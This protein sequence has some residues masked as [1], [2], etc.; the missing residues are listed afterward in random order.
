MKPQGKGK[1]SKRDGEKLGFPV[2]PLS[3]KESVGYRESGFFPEA[4]LNFLA[5]LGWNPGTEQELFS[6]EAL[7]DAFDLDRVQKS[8]ARFDPEKN[9]W[10]NHQYLQQKP[11]SDLVGLFRPVLSGKNVDESS[12]SDA[13]LSKAI[14]LIRERASF[15]HELW[16]LG[17]YLFLAPESY[18]EKAARKQWKP[19][20]PARM[21]ELATMLGFLEDFGANTTEAAVKDWLTASGLSFGQVMPPLR[22]VLVGMMKGPHLFDIME[23]LGKEET[24]N[25]IDRAIQTLGAQV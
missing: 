22:L 6:K 12:F 15:V 5:L 16:D 4:V 23:L 19:E 18:D 14:S 10:Y 8:G 17:S 11:V 20:T 3:W 7:I 13:Y 25:R 24:L 1:L 2:F 21:K 9:K